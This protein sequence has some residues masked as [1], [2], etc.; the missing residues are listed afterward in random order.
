M[1]ARAWP[2]VTNGMTA[3][4]VLP[5]PSAPPPPPVARPARLHEP[6]AAVLVNSERRRSSLALSLSCLEVGEP[7]GLVLM[8]LAVAA[9]HA[10]SRPAHHARNILDAAAR[11]GNVGRPFSRLAMNLRKTIR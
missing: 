10:H 1:L 3:K 8:A 6:K 4:N 2:V 5:S 7:Y 9:G 11:R